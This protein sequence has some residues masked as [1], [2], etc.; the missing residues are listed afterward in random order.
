MTNAI[1]NATTE[2]LKSEMLNAMRT[3]VEDGFPIATGEGGA[4]E[5]EEFVC[6]NNFDEDFDTKAASRMAY[7]VFLENEEELN[8]LYNSRK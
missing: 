3:L 6:E 5:F 1:I 8:K 7:D 2:D 4:S